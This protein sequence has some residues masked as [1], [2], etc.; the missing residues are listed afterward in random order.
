MTIKNRFLALLAL[1]S[2]LSL[3]A[4]SPEIGS[5]QWCADMKQQPSGDWSANQV[6]DYAKH[7]LLK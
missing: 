4:C 2:V 6:A 5:E 3:S 1:A 7:C